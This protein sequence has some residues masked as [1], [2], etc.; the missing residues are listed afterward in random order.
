M[1]KASG[2]SLVELMVVIL[3]MGALA[4]VGIPK[5]FGLTAKAKVTE[6]HATAGTYIHA[7]DAYLHGNNVIGNWR[8][9]G[10]APP[11]SDVF[12]YSGC[13]QNSITPQSGTGSIIGMLASN[14]IKLNDCLAHGAW[15]I[16]MTPQDEHHLSYQKI[17]S[18]AECA[19]L[20]PNWSPGTITNCSTSEGSNPAEP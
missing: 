13:V 10:F 15:A 16:V 11:A 4:A 20:T 12:E 19:A 17:A 7:Q 8:E 9:I 18:S 2:F 6:I 5:L 3:V 14:R 1:K